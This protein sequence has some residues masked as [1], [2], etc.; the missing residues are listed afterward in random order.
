MMHET[1]AHSNM[2]TWHYEIS[3]FYVFYVKMFISNLSCGQTEGL[4]DVCVV[5]TMDILFKKW[6]V[7][8]HL[9]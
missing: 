8:I 6:K 2:K 5:Y 1:F 3:H 4:C 9:K 7:I